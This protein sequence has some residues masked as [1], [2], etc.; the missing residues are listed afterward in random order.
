MSKTVRTL[1]HIP[2]GQAG[3]VV[4][5]ADERADTLVDAHLAMLVED[6]IEEPEPELEPEEDPD[7]GLPAVSAPKEEWVGLARQL[8][9]EV[10]GLTK[11]EVVALV[12][13]AT[14]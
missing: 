12:R 5:I 1:I 4:T 3:S 7:S 6:L 10:E 2:E 11:D 9:I 14:G 8:G 13:E